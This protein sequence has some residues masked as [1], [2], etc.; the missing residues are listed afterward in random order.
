MSA[1]LPGAGEFDDRGGGPI[2]VDGGVTID[3]DTHTV[4]R[5]GQAIGAAY[6]VLLD[7]DLAVA[8]ALVRA[9]PQLVLSAPGSPL[10]AARIPQQL[11]ELAGPGL[12]LGHAA[13][14]L[15]L[16]CNRVAAAYDE[17][18]GRAAA[19]LRGDG[20]YVALTRTLA[21]EFAPRTARLGPVQDLTERPAPTGIADLAAWFEG[22]QRSEPGG[23][24]RIDVIERTAPGP[25][26]RPQT[27]YTV[28][29]PG[30]SSLAPLPCLEAQVDEA[31]NVSA[32]LRLASNQTTPEVEALPE[33]LARAG[34]PEHAGLTLIGHSQGG[35]TALAAAGSPAMQARYG[36]ERV[37]TF[38]SPVARMPVPARTKVLSVEHRGDPVPSLDLAPNQATP[39]HVTVQAGP[40]RPGPHLTQ[41]HGMQNYVPAARR[42]DASAHPSLVAFERELRED[43][44]LATPG[45]Q[46]GRVRVRRIE[47]GLAP[48][49]GPT[50]QVGRMD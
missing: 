11:A 29:L 22:Y 41:D 33:A 39:R 35:M 20:A 50:C 10:T 18:E 32:N 19:R 31:R 1:H 16:E 15:W 43:G 24:G 9:Q 21:D 36:V 23:P 40:E 42:I 4:R 26:G 3:V 37:I 17:V 12:A 2:T 46:R 48:V 7:T 5:L 38:G 28:L 45:G 49:P 27:S 47:V 25:D 30:T 34:V 8:G 14:N 6:E 44:V 13:V